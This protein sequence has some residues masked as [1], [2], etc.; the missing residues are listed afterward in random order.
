MV[1]SLKDIKHLYLFLLGCFYNTLKSLA[2][3]TTEYEREQPDADFCDNDNATL[4]K[5]FS[6]TEMLKALQ[7][8]KA[9]KACGHY[10]IINEFLTIHLPPPPQE[11]VTEMYVTLFSLI[12]FFW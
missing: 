8:L 1:L 5:A 12:F 4:N 2:T 9:N 7:A 6:E 3:Y 10:Q 11:K